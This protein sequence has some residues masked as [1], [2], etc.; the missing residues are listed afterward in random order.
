[1]PIKKTTIVTYLLLIFITNATGQTINPAFNKNL[2][3]LEMFAVSNYKGEL[4]DY[5]SNYVVKANHIPPQDILAGT[6]KYQNGNEVFVLL[7][8]RV[9]DGYRGH[10]KK[11]TVDANGNQTT[12]VFNSDKSIGTSTKNWPFVIYSSNM[13][14]NYVIGGTFRDNTVIH[15]SNGCGF[16]EGGFKMQIL[17]PNCYDSF[18]NNSCALQAQWTVKKDQGLIDPNEPDFSVPKNVVL[19]KQ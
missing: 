1:M 12:E 4:N 3:Y 14:Q 8:W 11:I 6:W 16:I 19:T 17:N 7:L 5:D 15:P 18:G 2:K 10:Y 9:T 13:S